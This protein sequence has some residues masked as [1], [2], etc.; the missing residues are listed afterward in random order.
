M[1]LNLEV[2][3]NDI[4]WLNT[5]YGKEPNKEDFI[6]FS[7]HDVSVQYVSTQEKG[8]GFGVVD[9][10]SS[11]AFNIGVGVPAGIIANIIYDKIMK[12]GKNKLVIKEKEL[13]I[14]TEDELIIYI[15]RSIEEI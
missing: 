10:I 6:V 4:Q 5:L 14:L 1:I 2:H 8:K 12:N 7:K 13:T 9:L 11:L 15:E 3:S